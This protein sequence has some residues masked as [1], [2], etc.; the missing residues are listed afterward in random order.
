M[1][2]ARY[3]PLVPLVARELYIG[4]LKDF[5]CTHAAMSLALLLCF[6]L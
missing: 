6:Y 1:L 4:D 3:C 2:L 5:R